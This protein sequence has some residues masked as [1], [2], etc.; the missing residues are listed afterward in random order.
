MAY[1][2][3]VELHMGRAA[4]HLGLVDDAVADLDQAVK[5]CAQSGAEGYRAEADYELASAL[6]HR[7]APGD[8]ARART[9][10]VEVLPR[11]DELGMPPLE[12]RAKDL[13]ERIDS[14]AAA[15]LTRR[16]LEVADL[17]AQGLTNREIASRLFLSERTAQNHV[18]HILVKLDLPNRSQVALW[19]RAR[20]MSRTTE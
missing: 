7:S 5:A 14:A 19:V 2:G 18:Q 16:E 9:L 6:V 10:V 20:Q 8:L 17:V 11:M 12:A 4:A 15:V 3:P 13:L 1:G